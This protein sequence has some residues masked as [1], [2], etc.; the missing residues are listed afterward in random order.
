MPEEQKEFTYFPASS[1]GQE[2]RD[3]MR[4]MEPVKGLPVGKSF[5]VARKGFQAPLLVDLAKDAIKGV[6]RYVVT[7]HEHDF[8]I[9]RLENGASLKLFYRYN[10]INERDKRIKAKPIEQVKRVCGEYLKKDFVTFANY[11]SNLTEEMW[12]EHVISYALM[13][14]KFASVAVFKNSSDGASFELKRAIGT[15][16][17]SGFFKKLTFDELEKFGTKA[18]LY[19]INR[20]EE[21]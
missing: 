18:Q 21:E 11:D 2:F 19:K 1:V 13:Q 9:H 20:I 10:P 17:N 14:R 3:H 5:A 4:A 16:S 15:L 6:L 8:E 7:E 12:Q